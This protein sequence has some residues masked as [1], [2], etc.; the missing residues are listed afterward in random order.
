MKDAHLFMNPNSRIF[1]FFRGQ[2]ASRLDRFYVTENFFR[3]IRTTETH[4]TAF[5]D[6]S[7]VDLKFEVQHSQIVMTCGRGYWKINSALLSMN[8]IVT[9]FENVYQTVRARESF[10]NRFIRWWGD[11]KHK[12]KSFFRQVI[13]TF[14][15]EIVL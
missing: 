12:T 2:S 14:N 10:R 8:E 7:A 3:T 15:T 11:M 6:H 5:S 4:A 1:T 9:R 13:I